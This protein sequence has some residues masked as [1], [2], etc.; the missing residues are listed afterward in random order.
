[1]AE[2][3][4]QEIR[5][6]ANLA[7]LQLSDEQVDAFAPQVSQIL[8]YLQQLAAVDVEG[9]EP[10][11]GPELP[12]IKLRSDEPAPAFDR[13]KALSGAAESDGLHV[14]VPKFKEES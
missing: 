5:A 7:R 9:V 2:V 1:V 8:G 4:S 3:D 13:A 6:L 11:V 10:F 14:L 12:E